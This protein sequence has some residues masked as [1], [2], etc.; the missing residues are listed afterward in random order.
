ML[1]NS[2]NFTSFTSREGF[3]PFYWWMGQI[4][5][6]KNWDANTSDVQHNR[7]D[8]P[9]WG[10]R[11]KVRIFGRD[12]LI[13]DVPDDQLEMAEVLYPVT[14]GSGHGGSGQTPNLRQGTYVIGFYKDGKNA[15]Q[16]MIMGVIGNN[17]Q[18]ELPGS[19]PSDPLA[20]RSGWFSEDGTS[21]IPNNKVWRDPGNSSQPTIDS[22]QEVGH[23][24]Q[25]LKDQ[26]DDGTRKAYVPPTYGCDGSSGGI[27][28]IQIAIQ[29]ALGII[30][31]IRSS[32]STFSGAVSDLQN[33]ITG[34]VNNFSAVISNTM[35][36][37]YNRMRGFVNN[38]VNKGLSLAASITPPYLRNAFN[39]VNQTSTDLLQC[40]FNTVIKTLL[41]LVT[42]SMNKAVQN[43]INAPMCAVE[44]FT[45]SILMGG[46]GSITSTIGS[47][48][49]GISSLM[50][51]V[52][53]IDFSGGFG[54]MDIISGALKFLTCSEQLNCTMSKEWTLWYGSSD[55]VGSVA[56]DTINN[57]SNSINSIFGGS[58][59]KSS[60][61]SSSSSSS[62]CNTGPQSCG[63]PQVIISGGGGTGAKANAIIS[64]TGQVLGVDFVSYGS[65][66]TST[67]TVQVYDPCGTGGG[68]VIVPVMGF[69]LTA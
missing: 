56:T 45:S 37:I 14:A 66:Y 30:N 7:N 5:D 32:L 2:T 6:E 35:K 24:D 57:L 26:W 49:G 27:Q 28:G 3:G 47:V 19:N 36:T 63:P 41:S 8:I 4:V 11:Y 34:V 21:S 20:K 42:N 68:A 33:S 16:P 51:S 22:A 46:L 69:P 9:G 43:A 17:S 61:T 38:A 13:K 62:S 31:K 25:R 15:K 40:A 29:S 44:Q 58:S 18:T 65:G 55:S 52:G 60:K 48:M 64:S 54:A 12:S 53:K 67:P 59:S 50:G 1:N 10:Y 39:K 23:K